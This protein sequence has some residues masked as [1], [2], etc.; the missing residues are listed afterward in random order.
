MVYPD[1]ALPEAHLDGCKIFP[2]PA[3]GVGA[4]HGPS[5][6]EVSAGVSSAHC[7]FAKDF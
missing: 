4:G 5:G 1:F 6:L 2:E 3:T 7:G